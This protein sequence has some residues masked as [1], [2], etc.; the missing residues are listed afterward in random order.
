MYNFLTLL[1][2]TVCFPSSGQ[3]PFEK[4]PSI[5][6]KEYRNWK[7]DESEK[8][9]KYEFRLKVPRFFDKKDTLTVSIVSFSNKWDSSY[10]TIFRNDKQLQR[11]FEPMFFTDMNMTEPLRLADINGDKLTDLK[12]IA[13]YMGNGTASLNTRV[14]YLLQHK[15]KTFTKFSFLDKMSDNR[16]ERDFNGDGNYEI[17]TQTLTSYGNHSYWL[18]NLFNIHK[19]DIASVNEKYNYPILIQYLYRENFKVTK[20]LSRGKMKRFA[21]KK[22]EEFDRR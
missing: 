16:P 13:A 14:I 1:L 20:R 21:H 2:L 17:I 5:T 3:Y 7:I 19:Y 6:Y 15:N 12:L 11:F 9:K 10:I 8:E 18:F 4:S 22:P